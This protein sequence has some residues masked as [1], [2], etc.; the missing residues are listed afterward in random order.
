M[1]EQWSRNREAPGS[2]PSRYACAL[3]QGINPDYQVPRRGLKAFSPL[4]AHL[5][6]HAC[7]LSSQVKQTQPN[8]PRCCI[9]SNHGNNDLK[10]YRNSTSYYIDIYALRLIRD[11]VSRI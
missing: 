8:Q 11:F 3:R 1:V 5:Q 9:D 2:K 7:F 6:T 4:V 10:L